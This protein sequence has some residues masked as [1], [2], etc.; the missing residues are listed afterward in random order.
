MCNFLAT[1]MEPKVVALYGLRGCVALG[2]VFLCLGSVIKAGFPAS[3][4]EHY[5]ESNTTPII[6]GTVL[7]GLSQPMYQCTPALLSSRWFPHNERTMATSLALNSNQLGIGASFAIGAAYCTKP[8][9]CPKYFLALAA[10][11]FVICLLTLAFFEES[12][13]TPPSHSASGA[14]NKRA[15]QRSAPPQTVDKSDHAPASAISPLSAFDT[16]TEKLGDSK[17][18]GSMTPPATNRR[19]DTR[20]EYDVDID[21][22]LI[23][24]L[25]GARYIHDSRDD[26]D[27]D[28]DGCDSDEETVMRYDREYISDFFKPGFFHTVVAFAASAIVINTVSTYMETLLAARGHSRTYT[29][30]VGFF[31]QI[32]VMMSSFVVGGYTDKH[33]T[34]YFVTISLLVF[35]A[36]FLALCG[37]ALRGGAQLSIWWMLLLIAAFVGPLQPVSTELGV[38]VVYPKSE[39]IVL[40][41]QQLGANLSSAL[42]IPVF[43]K[44]KNVNVPTL[45]QYAFSFAVLSAMH[46]LATGYFASFNGSYERLAHERNVRRKRTI[47]FTP[48]TDFR[49]GSGVYQNQGGSTTVDI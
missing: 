33:R 9:S 15:A 3:F 43:E 28:D 49:V 45:P 42:F 24:N 30:V 21:S 7:I 1:I 37:Y 27:D 11:S 13:P 5:F 31:F 20:V 48:T 32:V 35:G 46:L 17:P 47:A 10:M 26:D 14:A 19:T 34:Y 16:P 38:E 4:F 40:V 23:Q 2:S 6:I 8:S 44:L 39:N 25:Q 36:V 29:G 18:P 22:S 12:P 41:V